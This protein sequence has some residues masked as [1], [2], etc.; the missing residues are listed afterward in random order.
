[1][2]VGIGSELWDR[3]S[4]GRRPEGLRP[5]KPLSAEGRTAP[6]TGGDVLLHI[7]SSRHDLNFEL[8]SRLAR[9][10]GGGAKV[11]EEVYGFR[12][13]DTRDLT[14]FIDGTENPA[15]GERA[16][17]A[18]IGEE[19]ASFAGGSYAATQRYVHHLEEWGKLAVADQEKIIGR[20]KPDST[21]LDEE[22]KP[23]TSHVSRTVIEKD[24]EELKIL[25]HSFPYGT[26]R[27]SGLFF[28]AY[29]RTLDNFETM[30]ARMI[31]ASGDGLHDRLI[32]FSHAVTGAT[33]FVPSMELLASIGR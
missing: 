25:R 5:F 22:T 10:F 3:L 19:D 23:A 9:S 32:E 8:A 2:N 33:F 6:A 7:A 17:V 27:E 26:L 14:G 18:L 11:L 20:T 30:L 4:H 13:L 16:K 21:E 15:G 31:G 28:I 12:Y 1:M 29:G 24:G